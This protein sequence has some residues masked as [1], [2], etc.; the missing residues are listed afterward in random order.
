[1]IGGLPQLEFLH[2]KRHC[3]RSNLFKLSAVQYLAHDIACIAQ[4][5][6]R[7]NARDDEKFSPK[8]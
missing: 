5:D 3:E 1:M 8:K 4:M 7:A 2:L 6:R